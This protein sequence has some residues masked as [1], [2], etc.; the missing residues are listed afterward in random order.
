MQTN[1]TPVIEA[2]QTNSLD[3]LSRALSTRERT[4]R[5]RAETLAS[6]R[7]LKGTL[8]EVRDNYR[9]T[10]QAIDIEGTVS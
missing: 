4:G 1:S 7:T 6:I 5:K 8:D 2:G 9:R 10:C 3:T